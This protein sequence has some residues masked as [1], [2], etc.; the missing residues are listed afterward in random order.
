MSLYSGIVPVVSPCVFGGGGAPFPEPGRP[1]VSGAVLPARFSSAENGDSR[2]GRH[3]GSLGSTLLSRRN[4]NE[5]QRRAGGKG[6]GA[7]STSQ[8]DS[9]L[10]AATHDSVRHEDA[11]L[12][13]TLAQTRCGGW[14]GGWGGGAKGTPKGVVGPFGS[15]N[16]VRGGRTATLP[17]EPCRVRQGAGGLL[18]VTLQARATRK[19]NDA[20]HA[21]GSEWGGCSGAASRGVP[22]CSFKRVGRRRSREERTREDKGNARLF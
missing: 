18:C 10:S 13:R 9:A 22:P 6:V 19:C 12:S 21:K 11:L 2:T 16:G 15:M 4:N 3:S 20:E 1:P 5:R 8:G 17:V 14:V 7:A